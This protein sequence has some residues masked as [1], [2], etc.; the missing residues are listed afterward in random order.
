[1]MNFPLKM[2]SK[3]EKGAKIEAA[4]TEILRGTLTMYRI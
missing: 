1:M 3:T 4:N 2:T